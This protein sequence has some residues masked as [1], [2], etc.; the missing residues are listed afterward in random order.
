MILQVLSLAFIVWFFLAVAARP[1][2]TDLLPVDERS[3]KILKSKV[4]LLRG[5]DWGFG[6]SI[7]FPFT[8]S[9]GAK[10][11]T[12]NCITRGPRAEYGTV[13]QFS[14]KILYTTEER[15]YKLNLPDLDVLLSRAVEYTKENLLTLVQHCKTSKEFVY[16]GHSRS[17]LLDDRKASTF[18]VVVPSHCIRDTGGY[19]DYFEITITLG[20]DQIRLIDALSKIS[21]DGRFTIYVDGYGE[22]RMALLDS[23]PPEVGGDINRSHSISERNEREQFFVDML[24]ELLK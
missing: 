22:R 3:D 24:G 18:N 20:D 12:S 13:I 16:L 1:Q 21:I 6:P 23:N 10:F 8:D 4:D 14:D 5:T 19:W 7:S 2:K 17:R 15:L 9:C 11:S